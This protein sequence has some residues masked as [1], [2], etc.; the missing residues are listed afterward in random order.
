MCKG[1]TGY[2]RPAAN[3]N[4]QRET[5]VGMSIKRHQSYIRAEAQEK[6]NGSRIEEKSKEVT[7]YT[8]SQR[9]IIQRRR[10]TSHSA[11]RRDK[12]FVRGR[13]PRLQANG[14]RVPPPSV[15]KAHPTIASYAPSREFA[16]PE[17]PPVV[18]A[19]KA[20]RTPPRIDAV[21]GSSGVG[22][23]VPGQDAA[24]AGETRVVELVG[25]GWIISDH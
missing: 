3:P 7:R 13:K 23:F 22:C 11:K 16:A 18:P 8:N 10:S 17:D 14:C 12:D 24:A 4:V 9:Q 25:R 6:I 1:R 2:H 19:A 5:T 15:N 21:G 20:S